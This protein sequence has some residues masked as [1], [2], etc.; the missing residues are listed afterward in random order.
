MHLV[1]ALIDCATTSIF[2]TPRL[3]RRLRLPHEPAFTSTQGLNGQLMMSAK[4]RRKTNI[5]VQYFEHLAPVDEPEVLIVPKKEYDLVLA[6][7]WFKSKTRRSTGFEA[8]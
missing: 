7:P 4:E 6:L 8:N 1:R 5:S 2:M 3:L